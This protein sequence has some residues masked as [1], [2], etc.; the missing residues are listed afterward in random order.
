MVNLIEYDCRFFLLKKC[1]MVDL[2]R[3][4]N[5]ISMV[6]NRRM[7]A[8]IVFRVGLLFNGFV[9]II[10][11]ILANK[12]KVVGIVRLIKLFLIGIVSL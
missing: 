1:G 7:G 10:Y 11:G 9:R 6:F 2:I 4:H 5:F 3:S 12:G 8:S